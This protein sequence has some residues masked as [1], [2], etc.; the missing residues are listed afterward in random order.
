MGKTLTFLEVSK[1]KKIQHFTFFSPLIQLQGQE[2]RSRVLLFSTVLK[3]SESSGR[4]AEN[5]PEIFPLG[6]HLTLGFF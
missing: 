6:T 3:C 4:S 1:T 5:W 2:L